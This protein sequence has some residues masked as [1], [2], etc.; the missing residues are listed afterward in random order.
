[1][2]PRVEQ[3]ERFDNW[4][5][6]R[7]PVEPET[8]APAIKSNRRVKIMNIGNKVDLKKASASTIFGLME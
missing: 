4:I 7:V 6:L 1:V 3:L 2:F 8:Q 5:K